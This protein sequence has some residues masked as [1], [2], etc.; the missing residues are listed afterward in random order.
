M[1]CLKRTSRSRRT[2]QEAEGF[3]FGYSAGVPSLGQQPAV[4]AD[5]AGERCRGTREA[6]GG[7]RTSETTSLHKREALSGAG[8]RPARL[9]SNDPSFERLRPDQRRRSI[10]RSPR[11]RVRVFHAMTTPLRQPGAWLGLL[12]LI[13]PLAAQDRTPAMS[14]PGWVAPASA[15]ADQSVGCRAGSH[16]RRGEALSAAVRAVSRPRGLAPAGTDLDD[17][18]PF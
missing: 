2:C 13:V 4:P 10:P 1:E 9:R 16:S 5:S 3:E 11:I 17:L 12:C 14:D 18:R 8:A 6:C 15:S 7:L